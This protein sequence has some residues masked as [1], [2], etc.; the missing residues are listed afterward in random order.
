MGT[1]TQVPAS[2]LAAPT[3]QA[4]EQAHIRLA[5]SSRSPEY[6]HT[7]L[8]PAQHTVVTFTVECVLVTVQAALHGLCMQALAPCLLISATKQKLPLT[9]QAMADLW[10]KLAHCIPAGGKRA[11]PWLLPAI[12]AA[13]Q[14]HHVRHPLAPCRPMQMLRRGAP[15]AQAGRST[16][17]AAH[18]GRRSQ[19]CSAV[20]SLRQ[21][22]PDAHSLLDDA[23]C[24]S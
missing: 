7:E 19:H 21:A 6:P 4:A 1:Q 10:G 2:Q 18:V 17:A 12:C 23:A 22:G 24:S 16:S 3:S 14:L 20:K 13:C 8:S 9:V 11:R 5:G 15:L